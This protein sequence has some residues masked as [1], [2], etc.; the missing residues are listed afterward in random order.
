MITAILVLV[1]LTTA[2]AVPVFVA[3]LA[4]A[5]NDAGNVAADPRKRK[6]AG[7]AAVMLVMYLGCQLLSIALLGWLIAHVNGVTGSAGPG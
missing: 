6:E 1:A 2:V 4:V 5:I 7:S 3:L